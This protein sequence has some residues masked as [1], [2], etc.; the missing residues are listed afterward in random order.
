MNQYPD[1]ISSNLANTLNEIKQ[2]NV[3]VQNKRNLY[4]V[5]NL[6]FDDLLQ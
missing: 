3:L 1:M 6:I 2:N 5:N 4:F